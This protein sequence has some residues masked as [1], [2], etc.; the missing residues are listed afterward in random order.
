MNLT[1]F[2]GALLAALFVML[3][4]RMVWLRT[5][6]KVPFGAGDNPVL[7]RAQRI[8]ANF[9]EYV[10]F[11]LLLTFFF[12]VATQ[13]RGWTHAFGIL[14]FVGRL[15]HAYGITRDNLAFRTAGMILTLGVIVATLVGLLV[16]HT[17]FMAT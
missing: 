4:V 11:A 8:H 12:E 14:L 7:L 3:S 16:F 17:H 15:L 9:A 2:Y 10:P 6:F 5:R 13:S 1:G